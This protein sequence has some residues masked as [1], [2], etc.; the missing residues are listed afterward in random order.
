[1]SGQEYIVSQVHA[2]GNY[3]QRKLGYH[4]PAHTR[5]ITGSEK[6]SEDGLPIKIPWPEEQPTEEVRETPNDTGITEVE[7]RTWVPSMYASP[8][9]YRL[10]FEGADISDPE[11]TY[12]AGIRRK[13]PDVNTLQ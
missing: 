4:L 6:W 3:I 13:E 8:L 12:M 11:N 10:D 9:G 5:Y 1:M 2:E 7:D